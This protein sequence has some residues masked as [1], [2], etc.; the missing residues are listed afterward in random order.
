[1]EKLITELKKW[2][3]SECDKIECQ[4]I[5]NWSERID[6]SEI[7]KEDMKIKID[8]YFSSK[9][10][11]GKKGIYCFG[12]DLSKSS[13]DKDTF[14]NEWTHDNSINSAPGN[15]PNIKHHLTHYDFEKVDNYVP[16]YIGKADTVTFSSRIKA[17]ITE[18]TGLCLYKRNL[19]NVFYRFTFA[20][21]NTNNNDELLYM[22]KY[23]EDYFGNQK[24]PIA[25]Y[26]T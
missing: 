5:E 8:E 17:H 11:R 1:M 4:F 16:L 20:I 14:Y 26:R 21:V 22:I 18:D 7:G 10:V 25:G 9:S 23:F 13:L 12:I 19:Q 2:I 24:K 3:N 15:I 6:L